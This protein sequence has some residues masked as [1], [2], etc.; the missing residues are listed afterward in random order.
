MA[1]T[2]STT[3]RTFADPLSQRSVLALRGDCLDVI[4][5]ICV[6]GDP[7]SLRTIRFRRNPIG[8]II[9]PEHCD[10]LEGCL[11]RSGQ[12]LGPGVPDRSWYAGWKSW[13]HGTSGNPQ[14]SRIWQ[15][16]GDVYAELVPT[17][18]PGCRWPRAPS[19]WSPALGVKFCTNN[20][21]CGGSI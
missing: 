13:G 3:E 20:G 19:V 6:L 14:P 16:P 1:P 5:L 11:V 17:P 21:D 8:R 7:Q 12:I 15:K 2:G 4:C 10:F 18:R 9:A